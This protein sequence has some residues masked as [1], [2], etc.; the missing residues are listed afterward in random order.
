M[1]SRLLIIVFLVLAKLPVD[2]AT[3]KG[4]I[5]ANEL[6][7]PPIA[8]VGVVADGAN[9]TTSEDFGRFT[10]EFPQKNPGDPVVLIVKQE[11][12]VVVNDVQLQLTLPSKAE[13]KILT[14]ILCKADDREEMA[15]RFYRL[16]SFE[17]IRE[18]Y[19]ER[20]T[21][22]K[23]AYEHYAFAF[24]PPVFATLGW[25]RDQAMAV[26]DKAAEELAKNL[27]GQTSQLYQDAK[28]LFLQ[29]KIT[30]AL[31]L[32]EDEKLHRLV[33]EPQKNR[34]ETKKVVEDAIQTW[35]LKAQLLTVQFRFD[36]AESAYLA[37]IELG[38]DSFAPHFAFASFNQELNRYEKA[39]TTYE[40]LGDS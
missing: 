31:E 5:L 36:E 15:R 25:E 30:Q 4:V 21:Q 32:L 37:A 27:P 24:E 16:K 23:K 39:K 1:L 22:L 6:S 34:T 29:G 20:L 9:P 28:R 8:K 3:L 40:Q 19:E 10:L 7:G 26:A 18:T 14:I 11:G 2:A 33:A 35:L 12:Y 38:P 13:D 17:A